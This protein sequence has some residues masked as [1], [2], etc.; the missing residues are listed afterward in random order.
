MN[1][2]LT[3]FLNT[4][5]ANQSAVLDILIIFMARILPWI[6]LGIFS[7]EVIGRALY[8]PILLTRVFLA[9]FAANVLAAILKFI[10]SK[11]RPFE[12][13]ADIT[14]LFYYSDL[15]SFPSGHALVFAVVAGLGLWWRSAVAWLYVIALI[16]IMFARVASGVHFVADVLVGACIGF[17]LVYI[18]VLLWN[19]KSQ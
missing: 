1:E 11:Q 5:V 19:K 8:K 7:V 14:P 10:F 18:L 6:I 12:I 9:L 2:Y 13:V 15:G 3:I 17:T 16:G 4:Y